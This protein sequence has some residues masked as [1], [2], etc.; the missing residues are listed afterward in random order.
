MK[1]KWKILLDKSKE[2]MIGA[3]TIYNN[4]SMNFK[5]EMF[6]V[7]S[8]IAW[9]YL[10]HSYYQKKGVNYFYR[11]NKNG[12]IRYEKIDN[13]KRE[14]ELHKCIY[15]NESPLDDAT[16]ANLEI[17]IQIRNSIE[18]SSIIVNENQLSSK[19]QAC[20]LNFNYY[21]K[22]L[23]GN[24]NGLDNRLSMS[25]QFS[26]LKPMQKR[27]LANKKYTNNISNI[28]SRFEENLSESVLGSE[29]YSYKVLFVE[30]LGKNKNNCDQVIDFIKGDSE[31]AS[32]IHIAIK[33]TE[34][35]K[36]LPSEI[37]EK[38]KNAGFEDFNMY[39]HTKI[40][41]K[42]NAKDPS[43]GYGTNVSNQWYWYAKWYE[44]LIEFLENNSD[45]L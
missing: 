42:L 10:L 16:R 27:H 45:E 25:I 30:V 36:F 24:E 1:P 22:Y 34:K 43:N 37:I 17:L 38:V 8:I 3:V 41:K 2:A 23:F 4:P 32:N 33:E 35:P 39:K 19:I 9:T 20:S 11:K 44:T 15:A 7:N 14:W 31:K 40:W 13:R 21:L 28:I 5:S 6:I 12:V 29:K 18:H 26:S